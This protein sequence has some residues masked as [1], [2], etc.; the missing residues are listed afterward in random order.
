MLV[1]RIRAGDTVKRHTGQA[2]TVFELDL[3][4]RQ[5]RQ[6]RQSRGRED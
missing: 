4:A 3:Q 1:V 6:K 2:G 5:D